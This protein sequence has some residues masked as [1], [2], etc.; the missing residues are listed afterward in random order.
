MIVTT[1]AAVVIE[2]LAPS[3]HDEYGTFLTEVADSLIYYSLPFK[4][5]LEDLLGCGSEYWIAREEGRITGVLPVMWRDGP[6]GRVINSLPFYG[7]NGGVLATTPRAES[8]L[9]AKFNELSGDP[10]V[11]AATWIC[12]P[13]RAPNEGLVRHDLTDERI[14]QFTSLDFGQDTE[15]GLSSVI[16]SSARRNIRKAESS[17]VSVRVDNG[18][19]GF[20]EKV[21]LD[22]MN[23]IGGRPKPAA[24][25]AKLPGHLAPGRDFRLYVAEREGSPIAALLL[26]YFNR[27]V[28]YYM[29]ATVEAARQYQPT[30]LLLWRAMIDA[31]HA[32]YASW[33][34][35]GTWLSQEGVW[36]FKHKWGA[37]DLRYRY[38]IRSIAGEIQRHSRSQLLAAYPGFYVVPFDKLDQERGA[39]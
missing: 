15:R 18:R 28:E 3:T 8:A 22:N 20:L 29:P 38:Y 10:K 35:G 34:W 36:R 14:G 13:L 9:A 33:N 27:T 32:G 26:L 37:R 1:Q 5:L 19:L 2:P 12:H 30:A 31:A 39:Q 7:S 16:D 6:W 23:Q 24:F 4:T 11:A 25:F 21:H 17:G